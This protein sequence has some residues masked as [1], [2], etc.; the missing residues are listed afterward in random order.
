MK[1]REYMSTRPGDYSLAESHQRVSVDDLDR[2]VGEQEV[3][4]YLV[5]VDPAGRQKLH[6][7]TVDS[8]VHVITRVA[9]KPSK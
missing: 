7:Y 9:R 2:R 6:V 4:E 5:G 8:G 1:L 3:E